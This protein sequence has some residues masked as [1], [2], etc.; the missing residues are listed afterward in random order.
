MGR[1]SDE[2]T[3]DQSPD[4]AAS[5]QPGNERLPRSP[6]LMSAADSALLIVD[7]Q[8]RLLPHVA[9]H[10]RIVWNCRRL[11]DGAAALDVPVVATE[12][13]PKGLGPTFDELRRRL[14]DEPLP[15]KLLFSCAACGG[16]FEELQAQGRHRL[17]L[18]GIETHVCV[19]QTAFDLLSAGWRVYLAVDAV[20]S[21]FSLDHQ[22]ALRRMEAGGVELTSTESA[23]FEWCE[24]AGTPAFKEVS[25]LA[26]ETPPEA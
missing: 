21:R 13:Y 15:E 23:L 4:G 17:L 22:T 9:D 26:R 12:Q 8:E 11:L 3:H 1:M 25:R 19:Q 24:Q 20:G 7:M 5:N 16:L 18:A 6:S 14:P 10:P 2:S